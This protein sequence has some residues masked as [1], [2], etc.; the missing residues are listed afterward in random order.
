MN[1]NKSNIKFLNKTLKEYNPNIRNIFNK[2]QI[3]IKNLNTDL[4]TVFKSNQFIS[5]VSDLKNR[6]HRLNKEYNIK[7]KKNNNVSAETK[8]I[9]EALNDYTNE[10]INFY[11]NS[12]YK[13]KNEENQKK[14]IKDLYLIISTYAKLQNELKNIVYYGENIITD[15]L[16]NINILKKELNKYLSEIHK[17]KSSINKSSSNKSSSNKSST[18]SINEVS[19]TQDKPK[20]SQTI[21]NEIG[22]YN[23]YN[24][25][26]KNAV[27]HLLLGILKNEQNI[28]ES[29]NLNNYFINFNNNNNIKYKNIKNNFKI[30]ITNLLNNIQINNI[31]IL[32]TYNPFITYFSS[33]INAYQKNDVFVVNEINYKIKIKNAF[34]NDLQELSE[35]FFPEINN[36]INPETF[37]NNFLKNILNGVELYQINNINNSLQLVNNLNTKKRIFTY[38]INNSYTA[39]GFTYGYLN[40]ILNDI[41]NDTLLNKIKIQ[42]NLI[43]DVYY[44]SGSK[45]NSFDEILSDAFTNNNIN[46][47]NN[48][49]NN[50]N[51]NN[52]YIIIHIGDNNYTLND[53]NFNVTYKI[54]NNLY[55][56]SD[57][58]YAS[59]GHFISLNKRGNKWYKYNDNTFDKIENIKTFKIDNFMPNIFL[60]RRVY[61]V[62]S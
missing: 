6:V 3:N 24:S 27:I 7:S 41:F 50:F 61:A 25:C 2:F 22:L 44:K 10:V 49:L 45:I 36:N 47:K 12:Y 9:G 52:N 58:V 34:I 23:N 29:F 19:N 28:N 1:E 11:E 43:L 30:F 55:I 39:M 51:N 14:F 4:T 53:F 33:H 17:H 15:K 31:A 35:N 59:G 26:Y 18:I 8:K 13:I 16:P 21:T 32:N 62:S 56:I 40:N 48:N 20:S 54:G 42:N 60:L 38:I 5:F 37:Y 57:I 46:L